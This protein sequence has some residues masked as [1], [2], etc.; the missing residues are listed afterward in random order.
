MISGVDLIVFLLQNKKACFFCTFLAA[1]FSFFLKKKSEN[2]LIGKGQAKESQ[3]DLLLRLYNQ[4]ILFL[5]L[6]T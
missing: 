1:L 2:E 3:Q 5:V 6:I 4:S